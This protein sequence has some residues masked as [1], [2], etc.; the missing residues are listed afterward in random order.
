[1]ARDLCHRK[2]EEYKLVGSTID[3]T[4]ALIVQDELHL[5]EEELGTFAAHYDTLLKTMQERL[6]NSPP[7]KLLAA[8]ATIEAFEEQVNHLYAREARVFPSPG[9]KLG[10]SFYVVTDAQSVRRVYVGALTSRPD[11]TEFGALAQ[12]YLHREIVRMQKDPAYGLQA[13]KMSSKHDEA[14]LQ[15]LLLN[16]ELTLGYVNRKPHADRIASEL[17]RETSRKLGEELR[18]Q[19]LVGGGSGSGTPLAEIADTLNEIV[20]QYKEQPDREKRLRALV[21]TSIISHGVDLDALNLMVVNNMTP[22]VAQYVQASSRSGRSHVGLVLISFDRRSV[23][24]RAFFTYFSEYHA[25]LDRMIAPVPVNRFARFAAEAT[26]PGILSALIVQVLNRERLT[27]KGLDPRK[28]LTSLRISKELGRFLNGGE[29]PEDKS[30]LLKELTLRSLGI[31]ARARRRR[32]GTV[33]TE[34]VFPQRLTQWLEQEAGD[35]FDRQLA[36]VR[37]PGQGGSTP[38]LFRPEP[39]RSFHDVDEPMEMVVSSRYAEVEGDL[40]DHQ[41]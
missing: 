39:L 30:A 31:G 12:Q 20:A 19:R 17:H 5:L 23:R 13:L 9:W 37:V 33:V 7:S 15:K 24:E 8:T 3:P 35:Q 40:T 18:V 32:N 1:M 28:P 27:A 10:E 26:M 21:A 22:T 2:A 36:H 38:A 25:F 29:P 34:P 11:V 14:W 16:Y 41:Q 4:P 6:G